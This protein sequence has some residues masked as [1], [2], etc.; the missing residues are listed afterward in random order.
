MNIMYTD[1]N[2]LIS[3]VVKKINDEKRSKDIYKT[4]LHFFM[5]QVSDFIVAS[6]TDIIRLKSMQQKNID[7]RTHYLTEN[8]DILKSIVKTIITNMPLSPNLFLPN[9][10]IKQVA[11]EC[12]QRNKRLNEYVKIKFMSVINVL[13]DPVFVNKENLTNS[14]MEDV[15]LTIVKSKIQ[16]VEENYFLFRNMLVWKRQFDKQYKIKKVLKDSSG[17]KAFI[18]FSKIFNEIDNIDFLHPISTLN[19]TKI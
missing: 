8:L 9:T 13:V 2:Y 16:Y 19:M 4:S 14:K 7:E 17:E 5:K 15:T 3:S 12:I 6:S 11:N 10:L 18:I 1:F